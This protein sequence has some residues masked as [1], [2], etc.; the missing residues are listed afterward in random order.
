MSSLAYGLRATGL[1]H[2]TVVGGFGGQKARP[3]KRISSLFLG[4]MARVFGTSWPEWCEPE[5][6][7]SGEAW[8]GGE[9]L[10]WGR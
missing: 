9:G 8:C 6:A 7:G 10:S 3:Q 1:K 2:L 5:A 4:V